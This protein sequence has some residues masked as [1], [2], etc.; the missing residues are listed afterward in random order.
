MR[1]G[2]QSL[3]SNQRWSISTNWMLEYPSPDICAGWQENVRART[4]C[5]NGGYA[6]AKSAKGEQRKGSLSESSKAISASLTS[7]CGANSDG[8]S[9]QHAQ[10]NTPLQAFVR[11]R[12]NVTRARKCDNGG[13]AGS[14]E[15]KVGQEE[16]VGD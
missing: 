8:Q 15:E 4:K 2:Q 14:R 11:P 12:G 9:R 13:Y 10:L 6:G 7:L 1:F 16:M 5:D 3:R